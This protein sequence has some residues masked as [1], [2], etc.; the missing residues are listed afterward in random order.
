MLAIVLILCFKRRVLELN[1]IQT[2]NAVSG[3]PPLEKEVN[4]YRPATN[5]YQQEVEVEVKEPDQSGSTSPSDSPSPSSSPK[6]ISKE[7]SIHY[8]NA[9]S[10]EYQES[11]NINDTVNINNLPPEP[12]PEPEY[13]TTTVTHS[14]VILDEYE[15]PSQSPV[16]LAKEYDTQSAVMKFVEEQPEWE[17]MDIQLRIDPTGHQDPIITRK[18]HVAESGKN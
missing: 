10:I 5:F 18:E 9:E 16:P 7:E 6:K 8:D 2:L 3:N 4:E 13:E 14:M 15:S 12:T 11:Y 17:S 1:T